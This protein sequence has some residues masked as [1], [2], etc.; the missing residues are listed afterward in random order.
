MVTVHCQDERRWIRIPAPFVFVAHLIR[1]APDVVPS[2][3]SAVMEMT[4]P[5]CLSSNRSRHLSVSTFDMKALHA[6]IENRRTFEVSHGRPR[7][8][9]RSVLRRCDH[10]H[11][12]DRR[13]RKEAA[14]LARRPA[15]PAADLADVVRHRRLV[16]DLRLHV[17]PVRRAV[18]QGLG[19]EDRQ[20]LPDE[21]RRAEAGRGRSRAVVVLQHGDAGL[22]RQVPRLVEAALPA[23]DSPQLRISRHV[24]DGHRHRCPS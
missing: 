7:Q 13:G 18:R 24:S 14:L 1:M 8:D 6:A 10:S 15:L 19:R 9:S 21:R 23:R 5:R 4:W 11:R 12:V 22:R 16:A 20:R 17:S 3:S 2:F